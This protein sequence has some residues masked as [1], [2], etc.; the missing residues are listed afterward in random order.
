MYVGVAKING[1]GETCK[2]GKEIN[3]FSLLCSFCKIFIQ[4]EPLPPPQVPGAVYG[5]F[6]GFFFSGLLY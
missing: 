6:Y 5:L 4:L 1:R 3:F 2:L